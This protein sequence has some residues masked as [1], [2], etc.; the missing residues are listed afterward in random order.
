MKLKNSIDIFFLRTLLQNSLI[1]YK[2]NEDELTF[3]QSIYSKEIKE[4]QEIN[5]KT[6]EW[7]T[8][9]YDTIEFEVVE[10]KV[11]IDDPEIIE[12]KLDKFKEYI[13]SSLLYIKML[14][15]KNDSNCTL[16]QKIIKESSNFILELLNFQN[17]ENLYIL[18]RVSDDFNFDE[19]DDLY[20]F[21]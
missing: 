9:S 21:D 10:S 8:E 12:L 7:F 3:N 14:I 5:K 15:E 2:G 6:F 16:Y 17:N 18:L 11:D 13:T 20:L 1:H 19:E 4:L